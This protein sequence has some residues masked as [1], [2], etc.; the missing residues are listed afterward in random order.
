VNDF[1]GSNMLWSDSN[2]DCGHLDETSIC[3]KLYGSNSGLE[4]AKVNISV[5]YSDGTEVLHYKYYNLPTTA[6]MFKLNYTSIDGNSNKRI[7]K[8]LNIVFVNDMTWTNP[9]V[10]RNVFIDYTIFTVNGMNVQQSERIMVS[11]MDFSNKTEPYLSGSFNW[12]GLY[13]I[14]YVPDPCKTSTFVSTG[15]RLC[16]YLKSSH[17]I[18]NAQVNVSYIESVQNR[19]IYTLYTVGSTYS[20]IPISLDTSLIRSIKILPVSSRAPVVLNTDGFLLNGDAIDSN[21]YCISDD[22]TINDVFDLA[23][24]S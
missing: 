6:A 11:P 19:T 15:D 10:D 13:S 9:L 3:F 2:I 5:V 8:K 22:L 12:Y 14:S 17:S 24:K 16:M 23:V 21:N 1:K 18:F 20:S 7:F 4:Q